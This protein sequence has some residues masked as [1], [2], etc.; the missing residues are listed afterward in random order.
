MKMRRTLLAALLATLACTGSVGAADAGAAEYVHHASVASGANYFGPFVTLYAAETVGAGS[1]LGCAGIRGV[2]GVVC[3]VEPGSKAAVI[4]TND[5]NSE[6]YIHNHSTFS[7]LFNG[8]Y[9][10]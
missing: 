6:P 4:L 10:S 7:G 9:Y 1:A 2:S 8:F 5:V 3:E